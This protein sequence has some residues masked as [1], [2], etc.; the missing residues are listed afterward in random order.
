MNNHRHPTISPALRKHF[1][2]HGYDEGHKH[3]LTSLKLSDLLTAYIR[4]LQ[5]KSCGCGVFSQ[6]IH[7]RVV[8]LV[9]QSVKLKLKDALDSCKLEIREMHF[10]YDEDTKKKSER[11]VLFYPQEPLDWARMSEVVACILTVSHRAQ[12]NTW[13]HDVL[14][15]IVQNHIFYFDFNDCGY[16]TDNIKDYFSTILQG[17][18]FTAMISF[19][20]LLPEYADFKDKKLAM[21]EGN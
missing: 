9:A 16:Y 10:S 19:A 3:S 14:A 17:Y 15:L 5:E 13:N 11:L 8:T 12:K 4:N 20:V 2:D 6:T 21:Q 7:E 18:Q 1:E